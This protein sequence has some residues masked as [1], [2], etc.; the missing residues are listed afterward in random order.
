MIPLENSI[1]IL[2]GQ[3]F[4]TESGLHYNYH[5]YYDPSTGRYLRA[6][7]IGLDGGINLYVYA[8]LNPVNWFD[9]YGLDSIEAPP[10]FFR[11]QMDSAYTRYHQFVRPD[12]W[13]PGQGERN[14]MLIV[15]AVT[16]GLTLGVEKIGMDCISSV[17]SKRGLG[18]N[19]FK[20]KTPKQIA[21]MLKKKGFEPRG[22]D[23]VKGKGGYVDPKTGRSYHIDKANRFG[24][25]PHV[26]VNR[27][28]GYK[29][30]LV[31][32]KYGM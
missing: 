10:G 26:D 25:P 16:V 32:H 2:P 31:K 6:D 28:R 23:P 11:R 1:R 21:K 17:A 20:G 19:P 13:G 3:Y 14:L 15:D 24:E 8:D 18:A 4:D 7:P 29:G 5:R 22:L 12:A 9:P 30:P 27:P